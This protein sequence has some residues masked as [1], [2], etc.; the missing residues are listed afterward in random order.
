MA[1]SSRPRRRA[2]MRGLPPRGQ[3]GASGAAAAG[4]R[5]GA[6]PRAGQGG[7]PS[8]SS[9]SRRSTAGRPNA[10]PTALCR[11]GPPAACRGGPPPCGSPGHGRSNAR[12]R[13]FG[14]GP[15]PR[16]TYGQPCAGRPAA[17][18]VGSGG[19]PLT[20]S[21]DQQGGS[22]GRV[23]RAGHEGGSRGRV[24][25]AGHESG[26]SGVYVR[27][28]L[29]GGWRARRDLLLGD[30]REGGWGGEAAGVPGAEVVRE[31]EGAREVGQAL[32]VVPRILRR[33]R[34]LVCA[35]ESKVTD[36]ETRTRRCC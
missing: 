16:W 10:E 3:A 7:G 26:A 18:L 28:V 32:R 36:T 24:T 2:G 4:C 21:A 29:G 6:A 33:A 22:R 35:R 14:H 31:V 9:R 8:P 11:G 30:G 27:G 15:P 5:S 34:H 25:R 23:T 20:K 13:A 17:C 19:R 1:P 12:F